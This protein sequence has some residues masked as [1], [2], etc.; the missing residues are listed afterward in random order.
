MPGMLGTVEAPAEPS[1]GAGATDRVP[2]PAVGAAPEPETIANTT[3]TNAAD[4]TVE[5]AATVN[6]RRSGV[7]HK[8]PV[9]ISALLACPNPYGRCCAGPAKDGFDERQDLV[10]ARS[11]VIAWLSNPDPQRSRKTR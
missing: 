1:G 2:V 8:R 6:R 9:P 3:A 11:A 10:S 5:I 4:A 7:V